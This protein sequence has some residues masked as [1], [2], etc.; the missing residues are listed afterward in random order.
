[1]SKR[2]LDFIHN[3]SNKRQRHGSEAVVRGDEEIPQPLQPVP[4]TPHRSLRS[5]SEVRSLFIL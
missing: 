4:A 5:N 2:L 1:M 3:K